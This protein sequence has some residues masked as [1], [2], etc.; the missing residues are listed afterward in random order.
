MVY[1]ASTLTVPPFRARE[2]AAST[3]TLPELLTLPPGLEGPA[4]EAALRIV[5]AAILA[6]LSPLIAAISMGLTRHPLVPLA[7]PVGAGLVLAGG[8]TLSQV[9]LWLMRFGLWQSLG[10]ALVGGIAVASLLSLVLARLGDALLTP[11]RLRL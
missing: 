6:L 1:R 8:F 4:Q 7:G 3:L 11:A 10:L 2:T 9:A 5:L